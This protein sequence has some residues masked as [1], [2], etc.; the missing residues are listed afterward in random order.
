M[1]KKNLVKTSICIIIIRFNKLINT[2]FQRILGVEDGYESFSCTL[3]H[4][5]PVIITPAI[6]MIF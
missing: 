5:L 1:S 2:I 6:L 4:P 3:N